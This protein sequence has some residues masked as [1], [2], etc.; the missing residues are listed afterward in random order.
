M[1]ADLAGLP[2]PDRPG[3]TLADPQGRG[4]TGGARAPFPW[5]QKRPPWWSEPGPVL[6]TFAST[7]SRPPTDDPDASWPPPVNGIQ[8]SP[9]AVAAH[10]EFAS[11]ARWTCHQCARDDAE[12]RLAREDLEAVGE[13]EL[14]A[15]PRGSRGLSW[16][17]GYD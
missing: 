17:P 11:G 3:P 6:A 7:T 16:R 5:T 13:V 1:T 9:E 15:E 12:Q 14:E 4:R 8:P 2:G 10:F